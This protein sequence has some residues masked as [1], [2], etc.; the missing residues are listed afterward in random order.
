MDQ[1]WD[2]IPCC[3]RRDIEGRLR[4]K[5]FGQFLDTYFELQVHRMLRR[6]GVGIEI[7]PTF[8]STTNTVDFRCTVDSTIFFVEA[9]VSG[10]SELGASNNL[11]DVRQKIV[12]YVAHPHSH[13]DLQTQGRLDT[14][15]PRKFVVNPILNLLDEWSVNEVRRYERNPAAE[16]RTS[17]PI[18]CV[19]KGNWKLT[20]SL[21]PVER[22]G[23]GSVWGPI[24]ADDVAI[25]VSLRQSLKKKASHWR[26]LGQQ[27]GIVILAINLCH[28]LFGLEELDVEVGNVIYGAGAGGEKRLEFS[29]FLRDINGV[30]VFNNA[31]LGNERTAH[32]RLY[33]NGEERIPECLKVLLHGRELGPLLGLK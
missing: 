25:D 33:R 26:E 12:K 30:L 21:R 24:E 27:D 17:A 6:L 31:T 15:L 22:G 14:T 32:L 18:A 9:T 4:S 3:H 11:E 28:R 8:S 16:N 19:S 29:P 1:E 2:A 20:A 5:D 13:V 7:H 23:V 10:I